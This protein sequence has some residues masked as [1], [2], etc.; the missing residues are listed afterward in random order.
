MHTS[1]LCLVVF[2]CFINIF[3]YLIS[4]HLIK[5]YDIE[6]KYYKLK[7]LV[8]RFI[9]SSS[10]WITIETLIGFVTLLGLIVIGIWPL[11]KF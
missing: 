6:T 3:G 9:K 7:W 1:L 10:L 2:S 8:N 5:F 11:F 4:M